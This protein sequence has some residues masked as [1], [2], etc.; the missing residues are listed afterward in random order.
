[1]N[2]TLTIAL[3][4]SLLAI[5]SYSGSASYLHEQ[6]GLMRGELSTSLGPWTALL[7]ED[8]SIFCAGTLI[9][10]VFILTA[11]SCIRPSAVK[12]RLGEF[13]R[14]PDELAEDHLV[15]FSLRYRLF[16]N[17]SL[18]NNIG[19]LKLTERVQ[20]KGYIMPVCI[21]INPQQKVSTSRFFG[22]AW[23]QDSN[24]SLT[25]E[26]GPILIQSKPEMCINLD[27]YT[28]F[29]A[30]HPGN[31][32]SCD[33]LAGSPLIQSS[34]YLFKTLI[35]QFGIATVNDMGCK[36]SQAYTDVLKFYW[37]IQDVVSVFNH[38]STNQSYVVDDYINE[39]F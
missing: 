5:C 2:A 22:N 33:G 31:L 8:G 1:M 11:A 16:N 9:T 27:L 36:E 17:D 37:W 14:F 30:G 39:D 7:H 24:V 15:H 32:R 18:A 3:L 26:F 20:I 28:Q 10:D 23:K 38:Y 19:L 35:V 6:C 13:G 29:C 12:V 34:R 25:K 4:A 21:I